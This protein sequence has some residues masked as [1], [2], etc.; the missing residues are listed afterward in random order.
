MRQKKLDAGD[1]YQVLGTKGM[2]MKPAKEITCRDTD[3]FTLR[4]SFKYEHIKTQA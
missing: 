3:L 2:Q 4:H 1:K